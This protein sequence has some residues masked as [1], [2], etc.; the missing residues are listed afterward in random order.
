MVT[1]GISMVFFSKVWRWFLCRLAPTSY[2]QKPTWIRNM[3]ATV[4]Q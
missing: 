1:K 4:I 2:M 3:R